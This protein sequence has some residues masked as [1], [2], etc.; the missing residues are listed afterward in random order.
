MTEEAWLHLQQENAELKAA[1]AQKEQRIQELE[2]VL[3][4]ALLRVEELEKRFVKDS[5]NSSL[6][7]SRDHGT[8]KPLGK[9][10]RSQK[11]SGDQPGHQGHTL[12]QAKTPDE[13][14]LHRPASCPSCQRDLREQ[15]GVIVE[16]RQVHDVLPW[17][18]Q[19]WEHQVEAVCC[20]GYQQRI[21]GHF[22]ASVSAP[23][24][25]GSGVQVLAVSLSQTQFLP[26]QRTCETLADLFE[27]ASVLTWVGRAGERLAGC[28]EQIAHW[29]KRAALMPV[30]E[31]SV[32]LRGKIPVRAQQWTN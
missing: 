13:V 19:V 7:P 28:V 23:V 21:R 32:H 25:D 31:T 10:P 20:P 27:A 15:P 16:R 6:L 14:I 8:R 9:R 29:I 18:L 4:G 1:L 5:H 26:V 22:P 12:M 3:M 30:D 24:Q 2:G 11:R 17:R